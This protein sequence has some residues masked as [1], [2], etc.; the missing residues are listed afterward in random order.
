MEEV[1]PIVDKICLVISTVLPL[2]ESENIYLELVS[3]DDYEL[4]D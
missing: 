2:Q 1:Q 3:D 4:I